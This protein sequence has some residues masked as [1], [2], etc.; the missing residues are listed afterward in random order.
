[1]VRILN[2]TLL[3]V[4]IPMSL[5]MAQ[6]KTVG[7][8]AAGA[9]AETCDAVLAKYLAQ[10]LGEATFIA[11]REKSLKPILEKCPDF[12]LGAGASGDGTGAA[13]RLDERRIDDELVRLGQRVGDSRSVVVFASE[14]IDKDWIGSFFTALPSS[15]KGEIALNECET[16]LADE[17]LRRGFV[18]RAEP[19]D[20]IRL[21]QVRSFR[22]V[23]GRYRDMSAMPN[24]TSVRAASIVDD[25][26]TAVAGCKVVLKTTGSGNEYESCASG[27]CKAVD[28]RS[29][30]RVSMA[31]LSKCASNADSTT[32]NISAIRNVCG[33][34]GRSMSNDLL[35]K[36]WEQGGN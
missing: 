15:E 35:K 24:F 12:I 23:V 18:R 2:I 13:I 29:M 34:M 1:M 31:V 32:A 9:G 28:M 4:I 33:D 25:G 20:K 19:L 5:A 26:A 30:Q 7:E 14:T 36:Y 11:E 3:F 17:F 16:A 6:E 27:R 21:M 22:T 10:R 8:E